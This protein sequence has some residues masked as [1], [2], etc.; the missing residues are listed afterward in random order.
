MKQIVKNYIYNFAYQIIVAV[1]PLLLSPYLSRIL[2]ADNLGIYS[3]VFSVS[4]IISTVTLFGTYDYGTR[5][6]AYVRDE[7]DERRQ[8]YWEIFGLRLLLGIAGIF[9]YMMIAAASEYTV[10]FLLFTGWLVAG[11]IDPSWMF[12]GMENMKPAIMKNL[13]VKIIGM[14]LVFVIVK[15]KTDLWKYSLIMSGTLLISTIIL[16]FQASK[17]IGHRSV[18]VGRMKQHICGSLH[19]FLPQAATLFYLQVDKIMIKMLADGINQVSWYDQAEK[20]IT[21][22]LT[23]IT[24]LNT[25]M[26]PRIANEYRHNET[27]KIEI[28]INNA[29]K[30]SLFFACP[31]MAG[32]ACIADDFVPWYLGDD[33]F[34]VAS[35][36][37]VLSP[38]IISNT[39]AGI[40]GKQYFTATNQIGILTKAYTCAAV[41][42]IIVNAFL[43]PG[44]GFLGAA[45]ATILSSYVSVIIQYS[46]LNRQINIR[47]IW[48]Y[49]P[50][51]LGMSCVMGGVILA[52]AMQLP[53]TPLS[54]IEE[55]ILGCLIYFLL[56]FALKDETLYEMINIIKS[57]RK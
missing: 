3:Y 7:S 24:V 22:P 44:W 32:I 40:S 11:M 5:Q 29:C 42:N 37:V 21:F 48:E 51:Y 19:L 50:K 16:V 14:L 34:P 52:V 26:M 47:G 54:T 36:I 27:E 25:V 13:S 30:I 12:V 8:V 9:V 15:E 55:V 41:M 10:Y 2:G 1:V 33:F 6:I 45:A 17:Y 39:L 49:L 31:M 46:V 43:I 4:Y 35:A 23:F 53:P 20:T 18:K 38:M 57:I 56:A 28:L